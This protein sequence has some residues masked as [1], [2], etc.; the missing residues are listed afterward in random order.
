MLS[1]PVRMLLCLG[2]SLLLWV[3]IY[4]YGM[5]FIKHIIGA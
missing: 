2:M 5:S 4:L 3:L 1:I